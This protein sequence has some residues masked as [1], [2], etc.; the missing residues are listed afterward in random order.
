MTWPELVSWPVTLVAVA[1][2]LL[3]NRKVKWCFVLWMFSNAASLA[4]HLATNLY[5][6]AVRDAI[7]FALAIQGWRLWREHD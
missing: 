6:L 2:V 5:G 1:G 7:F 4:V 3:N